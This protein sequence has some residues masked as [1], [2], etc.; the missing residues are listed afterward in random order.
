MSSTREQRP[1]PSEAAAPSAA[2][3][4]EL[5]DANA[6]GLIPHRRGRA[7]S[8]SELWRLHTAGRR[9]AAGERV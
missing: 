4:V 3:L 9:N 2:E 7:R 1:A 5:G 8:R 6:R